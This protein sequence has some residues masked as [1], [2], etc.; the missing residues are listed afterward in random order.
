M[1]VEE[2]RQAPMGEFMA[3]LARHISY[4]LLL[5]GFSIKGVG[6]EPERVPINFPATQIPHIDSRCGQEK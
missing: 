6:G 4:L 2:R 1:P 3:I 5:N